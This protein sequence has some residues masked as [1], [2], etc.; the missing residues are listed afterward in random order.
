M[1]RLALVLI[2]A[3]LLAAGCGSSRAAGPRPAPPRHGATYFVSPGGSDRA[4]GTTPRTA[5][6]TLARVHRARLRPGDRVLFAGGARFHGTLIPPTSGRAGA[7]I[8]FSSYGRGKAQLA[9]RH[10]AV[11]LPP[12]RSHLRFERLDLTSAGG[13]AAVL[14][15]SGG[16]AGSRDVAVVR[17]RLHDAAAAGIVSPKAADAGWRIAHDEIE[18]TGDSGVIFLGSGFAVVD[19]T[20]RA[21]GRDDALDYGKHG[22]YAKGPGALIARN[23]IAGY[24][25]AG[26][27]ARFRDARI[28]GNRIGPGPIGIAFLPDDPRAGHTTIA[29]NV[30]TGTTSAGIFVSSQNTQPERESFLIRGNRIDAA[31]QDGLVVERTGGD[32]ELVGNRVQVPRGDA[33]ALDRPGGALRERANVWRPR[34]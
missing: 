33:L 9:D 6:R 1:V 29:G 16:G 18:R 21:T 30:V 12:G 2:A 28:L 32:V 31:S 25:S 19:T 24:D 7:P 23:R 4:R 26:I 8:V 14:G 34:A 22:I 17:C 5:W 20:I 15:S 13:D 3:A 27:S 11:W 10:G